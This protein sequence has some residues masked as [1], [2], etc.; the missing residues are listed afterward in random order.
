MNKNIIILIIILIL[1][2]I[3]KKSNEMFDCISFNNNL[4]HRLKNIQ[5]PYDKIWPLTPRGV[6]ENDCVICVFKDTLK[7]SGHGTFDYG[8][9]IPKHMAKIISS[10]L[11]SF[12]CPPES[13]YMNSCVYEVEN[14]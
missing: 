4:N 13:V 11:S 9:Y 12:G 2:F 6:T 14:K 8:D 7:T 10:N 5:N 3:L 1:F